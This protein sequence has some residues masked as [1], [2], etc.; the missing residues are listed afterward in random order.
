MAPLT[1]ASEGNTH[2]FA[3][4]NTVTLVAT[5]Q[6]AASGYQWQR[7][8]ADIPGA[9]S[10]QYEFVM[11]EDAA[12]DYVVKAT[13]DGVET[14]SDAFSV[15]AAANVT[16]EDDASEPSAPVEPLPVFHPWFAGL[17]TAAA[18]LLAVVLVQAMNLLNG[19]AGFAEADWSTF[20]ANLKVAA[21]MALPLTIIGSLAVLVGL[22]MALVEWRGRFAEKPQPPTGDEITPKGISGEDAAK[23]IEAV[24][25]LRGAALSMVVGAIVL[26]ASAW[27]AQSAAGT[28]ADATDPTSSA[29]STASLS[30]SA[31]EAP[32]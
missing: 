11:S 7:A 5:A 32:R 20:A 13:V 1:I 22:W 4:G 24:G 6:G 23:V 12:N 16:G 18:I 26:I 3:V 25:K 21:F 29:A 30:A 27:I 8:G 14:A 31:S 10:S 15:E 2:T 17:L 28:A 19:R 9:T